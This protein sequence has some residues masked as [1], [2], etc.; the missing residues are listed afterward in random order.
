MDGVIDTYG[1]HHH[2]SPSLTQSTPYRLSQNFPSPLKS[3]FVCHDQPGFP[4]RERVPEICRCGLLHPPLSERKL[5]AR[6][7]RIGSFSS[8]CRSVE[9]R[10]CSAFGES[11]G[12][13]PLIHAA[14]LFAKQS[15]F[16]QGWIFPRVHIWAL[17]EEE[18]KTT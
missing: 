16:V 15:K 8:C 3:I 18:T 9:K 7:W 6:W 2:I 14:T 1:I 11:D 17:Q 10:P 4:K 12:W 5:H 13:H